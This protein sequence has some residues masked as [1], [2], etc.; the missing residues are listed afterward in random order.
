MVSFRTASKVSSYFVRAKVHLL[1]KTV[2]SFKCKKSRCHD[3]LNVNETDSFTSTV[4][5]KNYKINHKDDCSD[6]SL[7]YL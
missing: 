4:T 5:K 3:C 7:I 2:G 6:K 1:E